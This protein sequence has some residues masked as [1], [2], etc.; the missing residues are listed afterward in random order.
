MRTL[1]QFLVFSSTSANRKPNS[2]FEQA[3]QEEEPPPRGTSASL[4]PKPPASGFRFAPFEVGLYTCVNEFG[5][6]LDKDNYYSYLLSTFLKPSYLAMILSCITKLV[7]CDFHNLLECS[8]YALH[9]STIYLLI[10]TLLFIYLFADDLIN[11]F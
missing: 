1:H 4:R 11:K 8:K 3:L 2:T 7:S 5:S 10:D 6:Q 9:V